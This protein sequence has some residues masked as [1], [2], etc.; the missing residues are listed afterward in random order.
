M[1][2]VADYRHIFY[3]IFQL[4]TQCFHAIKHTHARHLHGIDF[5][6]QQ[7]RVTHLPTCTLILVVL[8]SV[9]EQWRNCW[10]HSTLSVALNHLPHQLEVS[11]S[12]CMYV[13]LSI[14]NVQ[15]HVENLSNFNTLSKLSGNYSYLSWVMVIV[16]VDVIILSFL[17]LD[18]S[19]VTMCVCL[20][21]D[22]DMP[23]RSSRLSSSSECGG[24]LM[25]TQDPHKQ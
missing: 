25:I 3:D 15:Y 6:E 10:S 9:L 11:Q 19:C 18:C 20:S 7:D 16:H 2:G 5:L 23:R 4:C 12:V 24:D 22:R 8:P 21:A 17:S 14:I 13:C 1:Y